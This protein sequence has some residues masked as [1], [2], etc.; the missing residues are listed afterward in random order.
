MISKKDWEELSA[1]LQERGDRSGV[2]ES[3][4]F[5]A[6]CEFYLKILLQKNEVLNLTAVRDLD[7]A[8]WKHLAD[9]LVLLGWEPLGKV[10]DWGSGGGLPGIPLALS[11]VAQG[12]E[13][14]I[15]FLDSVGKKLKAIEEFV[16]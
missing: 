16:S 8:F 2:C 11:R 15:V 5:R 4:S 13:A 10:V 12:Q 3:A 9:S 6:S 14:N 1:F 7:V